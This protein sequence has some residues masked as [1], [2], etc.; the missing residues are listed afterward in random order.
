MLKKL[1]ITLVGFIFVCA[2]SG[3]EQRGPAQRMGE[4]LDSAKESVQDTVNPKGPVEK[5]GREVDKALN[6]NKNT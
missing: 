5:S 3:C 1:V 4:K 2:L 6:T